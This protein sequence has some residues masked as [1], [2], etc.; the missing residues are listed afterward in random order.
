MEA[1]FA[2]AAECA[3][4]TPI[5]G[6]ALADDQAIPHGDWQ[7][8]S[9][10]ETFLE[11]QGFLHI[12][13]DGEGMPKLH[14]NVISACTDESYTQSYL[15]REKNLKSDFEER[16]EKGPRGGNRKAARAV[17]GPVLAKKVKMTIRDIVGIWRVFSM[18]EYEARVADL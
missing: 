5:P 4:D 14:V 6:I 18:K 3:M 17:E 15:L 1:H 11:A 8:V 2:T 13:Y 10:E 12:E 7:N 16:V 9:L